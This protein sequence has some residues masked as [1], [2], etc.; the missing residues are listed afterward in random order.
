M[1][2]KKLDWKTSAE[3]RAVTR[4]ICVVNILFCAEDHGAEGPIPTCLCIDLIDEAVF[5]YSMRERSELFFKSL[6]SFYNNVKRT[7]SY[8]LQA[9]VAEMIGTIAY[10]GCYDSGDSATTTTTAVNHI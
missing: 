5:V 4:M 3:M 6:G 9:S 2:A 10:G 1:S 7:S 8:L